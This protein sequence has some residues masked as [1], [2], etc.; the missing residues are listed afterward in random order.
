MCCERAEHCRTRCG[1][2]RSSK[3][4]DLAHPSRPY[5]AAHEFN[6]HATCCPATIF[7]LNNTVVLLHHILVPC[8]SGHRAAE[9]QA[10][11]IR[12]LS[13][14]N[15]QAI[16]LTFYKRQTFAGTETY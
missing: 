11:H 6:D 2:C 13:A 16:R 3:I 9:T 14:H 4:L 5:R 12:L 1:D 8:L 7:L 10:Y 15:A